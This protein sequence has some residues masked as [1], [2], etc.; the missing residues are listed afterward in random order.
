MK[1]SSWESYV[2]LVLSAEVGYVQ[3]IWMCM[4]AGLGMEKTELNARKSS[5]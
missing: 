1:I 4:K 5:E 3:S 2:G